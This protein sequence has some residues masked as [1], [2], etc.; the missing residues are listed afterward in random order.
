MYTWK[1][2][3][4]WNITQ[5]CTNFITPFGIPKYENKHRAYYSYS[6]LDVICQICNRLTH[7]WNSRRISQHNCTHNIANESFI[8][9]SL[10]VGICDA[11]IYLKYL[12]RCFQNRAANGIMLITEPITS[13]HRAAVTQL[14]TRWCDPE[15][16]RP[17]LDSRTV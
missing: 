4:V 2:C 1:K 17:I 12:E 11:S 5:N 9:N 3:I 10:C 15:I 7:T 14:R 6:L 16:R 8:A 13:M